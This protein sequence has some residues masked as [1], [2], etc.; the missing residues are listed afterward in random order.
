MCFAA[1]GGLRRPIFLIGLIA[2]G[3]VSAFSAADAQADSDE[4]VELETALRLASLAPRG[5]RGD[6][7]EP[8]L[9]NDPERGGKGADRRG[10]VGGRP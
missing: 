1:P 2:F 3:L 7:G 10:R 9:I 6:R 8:D 4:A 5:A